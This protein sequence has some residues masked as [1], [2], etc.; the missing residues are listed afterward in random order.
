MLADRRRALDLEMNAKITASAITSTVVPMATGSTT[1]E[2]SDPF[3][4]WR[5]IRST[6]RVPMESAIAGPAEVDGF[7][8]DKLLTIRI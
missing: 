4:Q 7:G 3:N 5:C 6:S 1:S 8:A 2:K